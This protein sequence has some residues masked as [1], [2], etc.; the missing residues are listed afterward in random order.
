MRGV[1]WVARCLTGG[2]DEHAGEPT[3]P[4]NRRRRGPLVPL[5]DAVRPWSRKLPG[6]TAI[7]GVLPVSPLT[8]ALLLVVARLVLLLGAAVD[9]KAAH[10]HGA[11]R[12]GWWCA[13]PSSCRWGVQRGLIVNHAGVACLSVR[14]TPDF[15]AGSD[16]RRGWLL[17]LRVERLAV[18][19]SH[20]AAMCVVEQVGVWVC[21]RVCSTWRNFSRHLHPDSSTHPLSFREET[22]DR[23]MRRSCGGCSC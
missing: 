17:V 18:L 12:C 6:S 16:P 20:L 10:A 11:F 4:R 22:D 3:L 2:A 5:L 19:P 23:P 8:V 9:S 14:C 13:S 15:D 7:M 1:S 21:V